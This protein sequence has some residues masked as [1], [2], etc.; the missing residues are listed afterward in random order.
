[1]NI[2]RITITIAILLAVFAFAACGQTP[3]KAG[4]VSSD[5]SASDSGAQPVSYT[6]WYGKVSEVAGNELTLELAKQPGEEEQ[7]SSSAPA[8]DGETMQAT[9]MSPALPAGQADAGGAEQR[10]E[11]ELTRKELAILEYMM[12]HPGRVISQEELMEHV[13]NM[14]ADSFSNAVR[15]HIASLR[16][17]I[18]AL[19]GRDLIATRIGQGYCLQEEDT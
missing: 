12:Q 7:Q 17:K 11:L 14:Q 13:W 8:G 16:R 4:Q 2:K 10:E 9:M 18:R 5:S 6:T 19:C 1:M 15:V 3:D